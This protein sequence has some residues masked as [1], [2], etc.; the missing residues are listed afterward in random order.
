MWQ[1]TGKHRPS[2]ADKTEAGQESVWDYP[3]P[4]VCL[5]DPR[6]IVVKSNQRLIADT[7]SA[8]RVLETASPPT[9]YIPA[10]DVDLSVLRKM[11][12]SSY[13]EWKGPATYWSLDDGHQQI[14]NVG[15]SYENPTK[16]FREMTGFLSFYPALVT[17]T[18]DE[19]IVQP[20][21]GGFYGGWVTK[22]IVGPWKGP[23]GT[24]GW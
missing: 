21:A 1:F 12:G 10:D 8:V 19:E 9:V 22:E 13:C 18:I 11:S 6:R 20:Q 16:T 4:P 5:P 23:P 24:G 15:W 17:C 14:K 2:F 3:R 7:R